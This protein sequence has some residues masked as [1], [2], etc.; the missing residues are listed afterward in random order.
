[1]EIKARA[2]IEIAGFPEDHIKKTMEMVIE[3]LGK[4]KGIEIINKNIAPVEHT[5][6]MWSTFAEL[7][8]KFDDMKILNDFCF[9]YMPS[10][11]EISDPVKLNIDSIDVSDFLNDL[12]AKLHNFT[13][14]IK[15]L[16]AENAILKKEKEDSK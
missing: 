15:N 7:D 9:N 4:E 5:Q 10:S 6:K 13:M 3:N 8:L 1:M 14:Y 16:Q 2:I 12:L 11:I